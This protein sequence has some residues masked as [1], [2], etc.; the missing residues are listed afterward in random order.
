MKGPLSSRSHNGGMTFEQVQRE[1][2]VTAEV[3]TQSL[4]SPR[5][6]ELTGKPDSSIFVT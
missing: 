4:P 2:D 5:S 3:F 6:A 1:Y